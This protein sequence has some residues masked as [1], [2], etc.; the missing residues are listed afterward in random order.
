M[1]VEFRVAPLGGAAARRLGY[2]KRSHL[3]S[4][5]LMQSAEND[6]FV[7][8]PRRDLRSYHRPGL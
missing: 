3:G 4:M 7:Y 1:Q 8:R 2:H 5:A 6:Q